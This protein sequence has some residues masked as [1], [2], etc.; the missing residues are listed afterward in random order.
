MRP[1]TR[2]FTEVIDGGRLEAEEGVVKTRRY[3]ES[4]C[5]IDKSKVPVFL[6]GRLK[7][8]G[9]SMLRLPKEDFKYKH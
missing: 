4:D 7:I 1:V 5:V 6:S 9:L 8:Q 2:K 3:S